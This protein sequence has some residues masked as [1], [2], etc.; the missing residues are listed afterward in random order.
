MGGGGWWT[1]WSMFVNTISRM[2]PNQTKRQNA[3]IILSL[4]RLA[5]ISSWALIGVHT[6]HRL[7]CCVYLVYS[8]CTPPHCLF[9]IQTF[10][11][12]FFPVKRLKKIESY[13]S[14]WFPNLNIDQ[15]HKIRSRVNE[16]LRSPGKTD[17]EI[18]RPG[19]RWQ[20]QAYSMVSV[21]SVILNKT[22]KTELENCFLFLFYLSFSGR[23]D[24]GRR[25][26]LKINLQK[27]KVIYLS[28][29][30][31]LDGKSRVNGWP[32]MHLKSNINHTV[33]IQ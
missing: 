22:L 33:I 28:S 16:R 1:V 25:V 7:G 23:G 9:I 20:I 10:T 31:I 29:I 15:W 11:P 17:S 26:W 14:N 30:H 18:A 19:F 24:V 12:S 32:Y 2:C 3:D 13:V 8:Y 4:S 27:C 5:G 21:M 6:A